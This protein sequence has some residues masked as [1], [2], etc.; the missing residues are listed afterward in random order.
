MD[1]SRGLNAVN[2]VTNAQRAE[3]GRAWVHALANKVMIVKYDKIIRDKVPEIIKANDGK[4]DTKV[5]NGYEAI[6]YLIEKI[7]EE[8]DEL[9]EARNVEGKAI[10]ELGDILEC[11]CAIAS[12]MSVPMERIDFVRTNKAFNRGRFDNNIILLEATK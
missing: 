3:Q 4:C 2:V 6:G 10:E 7:H 1:I 9:L 5:V 8:A 12:K 11:V